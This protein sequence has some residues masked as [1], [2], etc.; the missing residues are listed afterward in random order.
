MR[1]T[2]LY[3]GTAKLKF[4]KRKTTVGEMQYRISLQVI[5]VVII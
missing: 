2:L 5:P 1:G 4:Y 3:L